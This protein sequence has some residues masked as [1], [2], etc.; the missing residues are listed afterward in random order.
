MIFVLLVD[1]VMDDK[2]LLDRKCVTSSCRTHTF[3]CDILI[4]QCYKT[5]DFI[6][7][8]SVKILN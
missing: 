3:L 1:Y 5:I 6:V 2:L 7:Y 8:N 4:Y